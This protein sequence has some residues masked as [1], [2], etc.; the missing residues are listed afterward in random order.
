M[1]T[2]MAWAQLANAAIM[3]VL[4]ALALIWLALRLERDRR[5]MNHEFERE[6]GSGQH[7]QDVATRRR[8]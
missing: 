8:G 4:P 3:I 6:F 1:M 2:S 5:K 7:D